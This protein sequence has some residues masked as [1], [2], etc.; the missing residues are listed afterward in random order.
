M[1]KLVSKSAIIR[2]KMKN[3]KEQQELLRIEHRTLVIDHNNLPSRLDYRGFSKVFDSI[4]EPDLKSEI[5]YLSMRTCRYYY[6]NH[7]YWCIQS[8]LWSID[9]F[10]SVFRVSFLG[11]LLVKVLKIICSKWTWITDPLDKQSW[12][13]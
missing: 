6:I 3:K 4:S 8:S 10:G 1:S 2:T 11:T 7:C 12:F 13:I 9:L 5:K